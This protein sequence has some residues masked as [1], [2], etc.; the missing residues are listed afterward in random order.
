M[1]NFE[2]IKKDLFRV[3]S[4]YVIAHCISRDVQMKKG[5]A[6]TFNRKYPEMQNYVKKNNSNVPGVVRYESSSRT[7]YNLITKNLY[8]EKPTRFNFDKA[9]YLLFEEMESKGEKYLAIPM[10]GSGL[11][12]LIWK[13]T[14]KYIRELSETYDINVLVCKL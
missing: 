9:I 2:I 12:K 11:D 6:N 7:I 13:K 8:Y 3:D 10:L 4:K 1:S 5:I 14:E